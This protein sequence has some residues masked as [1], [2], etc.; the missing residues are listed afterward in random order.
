M[1]VCLCLCLCVYVHLC[2]CVCVSEYLCVCVCVY[3]YMC[4][5]LCVCLCVCLCVYVHLCTCV[6]VSE[7]LCVFVYVCGGG[8]R[9]DRAVTSGPLAQGCAGPAGQPS[10]HRCPT[11]ATAWAGT[12]PR[13][14]WL[15]G[16]GRGQKQPPSSSSGQREEWP[17]C[18][19]LLAPAD[20]VGCQSRSLQA[21]ACK[22]GAQ[23]LGW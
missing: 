12:D 9:G 2:T 7:Y 17:G 6:C 15:D 13:Q 20:G 21:R 1:C 23:L 8:E 5:P 14:A 22:R 19:A 4:V 10:S 11:G 18:G 16:E 3:V